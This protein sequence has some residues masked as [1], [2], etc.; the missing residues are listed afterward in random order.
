[1]KR[2]RLG[3]LTARCNEATAR[4]LVRSGVPHSFAGIQW[5]AGLICTVIDS[6][7]RTETHIKRQATRHDCLPSWLAMGTNEL[8]K[9]TTRK[10]IFCTETTKAAKAGQKSLEPHEKPNEA[11]KEEPLYF[12][13]LSTPFASVST[14]ATPLYTVKRLAIFPSPV[15]ISLNKLSLVRNN[16]I[17]PSQGELVSDIPTR[18][19]KIADLFLQCSLS[20]TSHH[21]SGCS[22]ASFRQFLLQCKKCVQPTSNGNDVE[23][24]RNE[25]SILRHFLYRSETNKLI[26]KL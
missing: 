7:Y 11:T 14:G 22:A 8:K 23:A 5:P 2:P 26:L 16:L 21:A 6:L 12:Y 9:C 3:T 4:G 25:A 20:D 17:I 18:D 1:L 19:G 15:G 24:K 13:S 10:T